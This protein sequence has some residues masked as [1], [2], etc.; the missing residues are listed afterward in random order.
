VYLNRIVRRGNG[1]SPIGAK[2]IASEV[3][4]SPPGDG[5]HDGNSVAGHDMEQDL[6]S[7]FLI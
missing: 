1:R 2:R 6:I 5:T 4:Y 3:S 7:Y